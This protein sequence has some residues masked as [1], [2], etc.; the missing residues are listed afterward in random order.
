VQSVPGGKHMMFV[1][2]DRR[3]KCP[4]PHRKPSEDVERCY[5]N[6]ARRAFGLTAENG[7]SDEEFYQDR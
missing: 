7:I 1:S 5:V 3:R 4:I 2:S 6:A